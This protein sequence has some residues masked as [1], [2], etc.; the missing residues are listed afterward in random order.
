LA[1]AGVKT[2]SPT[3]APPAAS[4]PPVRYKRALRNY[5]IDKSLQLRYVV[6]VT[7]LSAIITGVLGYFV[8]DQSTYA[9][10]KIIASLQAPDM[11]WLDLELKADIVRT[12]NRSDNT[13]LYVM[14]AVGIGLCAL[15]TLY[16]IVMTHRV[17][18]PL[19]KVGMY[20]DRIREG[21]NPKVY[22]LRA[23]DQLQDFFAK[24]KAMS[25]AM[26][27]RTQ[28]DIAAYDG[29]LGACATLP[30]SGELG[31]VLDELRALA[32]ERQASLGK[33]DKPGPT[34]D[35]GARFALS[36]GQVLGAVL[37]LCGGALVM[38]ATLTNESW[39]AMVLFGLGAIGVMN[40][41]ST[42]SSTKP[43]GWPSMIGAVGGVAIL[44]Y[45]LRLDQAGFG[46]RLA[47]LD[48]HGR[49]CLAG[50]GLLA[51]A[52]VVIRVTRKE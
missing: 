50:V 10:R 1:D 12:L 51:V 45:L 41:V 13:L 52:S 35:P 6:S 9:S 29:F 32:R 47:H 27:A 3:P 36:S 28:A 15:L 37:A 18:G 17:A 40:G 16:L 7:T 14:M 21:E 4:A 8:W 25:D 23:G 24:F 46:A 11:D 5:L 44:A 31:H 33:P 34:A 2:A 39:L 43:K 30:A 48:W 26:R 49:A 38:G 20:F 19:Y 42:F 22:D